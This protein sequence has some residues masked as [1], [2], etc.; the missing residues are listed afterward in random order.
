MKRALLALLPLLAACPTTEYVWVKHGAS[1]QEFNQDAGQCRA[2]AFSV[3][4]ATSPM[5]A[6]QVAI[7]YASCM[8]GKGWASEERPIAGSR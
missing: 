3:P 2:Q 5:M 6:N 4:G 8:Q 7:I 1:Q